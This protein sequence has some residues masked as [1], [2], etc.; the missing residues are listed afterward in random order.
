MVVE[1]P[2]NDTTCAFGRAHRTHFLMPPRAHLIRAVRIPIHEE[3]LPVLHQ[4]EAMMGI[5]GGRAT[6]DYSYRAFYYAKG[7]SDL[8]IK[9]PLGAS[10]QHGNNRVDITL[11]LLRRTC[12]GEKCK[13]D[14]LLQKMAA[15]F[16]GDIWLHRELLRVNGS[17]SPSDVPH[18]LAAIAESTPWAPAPLKWGEFSGRGYLN[19]YL[20]AR[21][22]EAGVTAAIAEFECYNQARTLCVLL[23]PFESQ[24]K[25]A[26]TFSC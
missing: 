14:E 7:C 12:V 20:A 18:L 15:D 9:V 24:V 6:L 2:A 25:I 4:D 13:V 23:V 5:R 22:R 3:Y 26:R 1:R 16:W 17:I 21:M 10:R 11:R 8:Y 19:H